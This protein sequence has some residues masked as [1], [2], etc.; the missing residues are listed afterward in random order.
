MRSILPVIVYKKLRNV[1]LMQKM[2]HYPDR[3]YMERELIPAIARSRGKILFVGCQYFT[4]HYPALFE[5]DGGE[6]WTIDIDPSV[7]R[8][9]APG[10]HVIGSFQ[11][12]RN[13]W[14]VA[15]FDCIVISGVFGYGINSKED[16]NEA[17]RVCSFLLKS[18]GWLILGWN[19][20]KVNEVKPPALSVLQR[21]YRPASLEGLEH[22]K[23]FAGSTHVYH[24]F[25]STRALSD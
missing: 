23:R 7:A 24:T 13:H 5:M 20:D 10:R 12:A 3:I 25:V 6:C 11:D 16:Q 4:K 9:G 14:P 2:R 21:D 8:W 19:K 1:Y 15:S 17:L 22:S 18:G